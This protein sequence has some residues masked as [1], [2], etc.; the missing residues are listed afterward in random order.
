MADANPADAGDQFFEPQGQVAFSLT[1]AT[2]SQGVINYGTAEGM[3]IY[4]AAISKLADDSFDCE[5]SGLRNFLNLVRDRAINNGWDNSILAIPNDLAQP[6]GATTN[7]L[8]RYSELTMER[9]KA[10]GRTYQ[11]QPVRAAQDSI[12]L[13]NC[14][15]ASLSTVGQQKVSV[16]RSDY[17]EGGINSGVLLLKVIIQVSHIDTNATTTWIRTQLSNL[18]TYLPTV[19]HDIEKF[20]QYVKTLLEQLRARGEVTHDMLPNLLK[21]YK[22]AQDKKFVEYIEKKEGEYEDG[23]DMTH[24]ALMQLAQ[25]K[26]QV[27]KLKGTWNAPSAEEEKIIALEAKIQKLERQAKKQ[28]PKSDS[29][30]NNNVKPSSKK[31]GKDLKSRKKPAWMLKPPTDA[32]KGKSKMVDKK[33]YHWCPHHKSW[34]RH[35]PAECKGTGLAKEGDNRNKSDTNKLKLTK[36]LAALAEEDGLDQ[37]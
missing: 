37:E 18:D 24:E 12:Q 2:H 21:G 30:R 16:Y 29:K 1:P 33:E 32:E 23:E 10:F 34:V 14:L 3:R 11:A 25:N 20:N 17:E 5:P 9:L 35:S 27:L 7:F 31:K 13:Y 6:L 19:G 28:V 26:F 22:A 15:M 36:A 8:D 4:N